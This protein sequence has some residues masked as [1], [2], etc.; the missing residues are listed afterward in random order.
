MR[1]AAVKALRNMQV[2]RHGGRWRGRDAYV[3][4]LCDESIDAIYDAVDK[5]KTQ[6]IH[7]EGCWSWGPAHYEC[8]CAEVAKANGWKK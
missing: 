5:E 6:H 8:A 1:A 7:G 4:T 3:R 2:I